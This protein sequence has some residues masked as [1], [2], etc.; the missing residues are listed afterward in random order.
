MTSKIDEKKIDE[1]LADISNQVDNYVKQGR[2]TVRYGKEYTEIDM[3]KY[4]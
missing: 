1:R 2:D 4:I 3:T